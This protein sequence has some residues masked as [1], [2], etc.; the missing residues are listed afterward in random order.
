[1]NADEKAT[2]FLQKALKLYGKELSI[3]S[4]QPFFISE[5]EDEES[6]KTGNP[7]IRVQYGFPQ[8]GSVCVDF[9]IIIDEKKAEMT[10]VVVFTQP[11]DKDIIMANYAPQSKTGEVTINANFGMNTGTQKYA[12]FKEIDENP[13]AL[14]LLDIAIEDLDNAIIHGPFNGS[15]PMNS[16]SI[17][18]CN[19][20]P[21][22]RGKTK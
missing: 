15:I 19:T 13:N 17:P 16:N 2:L 21:Y 18:C 7:K 8:S 22:E 1:M 5:I 6:K 20:I 10:D 9:N 14:K 11:S 3:P 12:T 4:N